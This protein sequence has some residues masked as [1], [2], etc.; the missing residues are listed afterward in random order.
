ME[1]VKAGDISLEI[2]K[3]VKKLELNYIDLPKI[4]CFRSY[5]SSA[6]ARARIWSFPKIRGALQLSS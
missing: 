3:I 1:S 4:T 2:K 5:G 6:R